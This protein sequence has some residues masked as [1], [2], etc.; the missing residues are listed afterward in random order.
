MQFTSRLAPSERS[1]WQERLPLETVTT[2]MSG[3]MATELE[4]QI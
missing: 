3:A 4:R 1:R 2:E